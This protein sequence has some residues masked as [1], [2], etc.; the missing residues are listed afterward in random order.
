MFDRKHLYELVAAA[1]IAITGTVMG[2]VAKSVIDPNR[3]IHVTKPLPQMTGDA[4]V[5]PEEPLVL[6]RGDGEV[7]LNNRATL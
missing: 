3:P 7:V 5:D 1:M 6:F 4:P 2:V